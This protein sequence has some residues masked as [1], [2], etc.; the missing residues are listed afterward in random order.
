MDRTQDR[1]EIVFFD[2]ETIYATSVIVEFGAI[3][4]CPETLTE[5]HNYSTLVRP[6]D[7]SIIPPVFERRNGITRDA[8]AGAPTFDDIADTV[9]ELLHD[10]IWAG[11]NILEH[12]C[13]CISEAFA[14]INRPPPE[15]K[16]F[17]DSL[18]SLTEKFGS[19]AGNMKMATL[20]AYFGLGEQ[21]HRSLDDVRMNLDVLKHCAAVLFLESSLRDTSTVNSRISPDATT[22]HSK[23]KSLPDGSSSDA[24]Q[25]HY[26]AFGPFHD[27][28]NKESIRS[29][30]FSSAAVSEACNGIF[31]V[32]KLEEISISCLTPRLVQLDGG[33]LKIQLLHKGLPFQLFCVNLKIRY[34]VNAKFRDHVGRPKLNFVVD[35]SQRLRE[36]LEA[37]DNMAERLSF[38][39][40]GSSWR[41]IV[42]W[43]DGFNYPFVRLHIPAAECENVALYGAE[44]YRRESSGTIKR[45]LFNKFDA[46]E[47]SSLFKRGTFV[48]AV[49]SLDS[50]DY[51]QNA[52]I[53][54]IARGLT[55]H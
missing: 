12:D 49:F 35:A 10:R 45:L 13:L 16:G 7:P 41:W 22:S 11:H 36:V 19:R 40:G 43:E 46:G 54:L 3:L 4:V 34:G 14:E 42:T 52:G 23:E 51:Q 55:I 1:S 20:A 37:C 27:E 9:Y 5:R 8:L 30:M 29:Q 47:M 53:R 48:D 26:F 33:D 6:S 24:V 2:V 50:Y 28:T 17:I 44:I 32:L 25:Q 38:E 21:T 18:V 31:T 39:S 15:P